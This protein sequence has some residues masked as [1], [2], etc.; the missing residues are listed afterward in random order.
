MLSCA[1]VEAQAAPDHHPSTIAPRIAAPL[2]TLVIA[3]AD[4]F[5]SNHPAIRL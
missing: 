3:A 5:L 2:Q 1:E 4:L